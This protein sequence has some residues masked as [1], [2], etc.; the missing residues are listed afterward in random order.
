[1]QLRLETKINVKLKCIKWYRAV[2]FT[3]QELQKQISYL[4]PD[5]DY[6]Q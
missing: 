6:F 2:F 5:I 4:L 3:D 1:M